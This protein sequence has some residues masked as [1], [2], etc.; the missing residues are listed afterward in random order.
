M[1]ETVSTKRSAHH[2]LSAVSTACT[3]SPTPVGTQKRLYKQHVQL[4]AVDSSQQ[5]QTA[6]NLP[7]DTLLQHLCICNGSNR[8]CCRKEGV[9]HP[10]TST[11]NHARRC[12]CLCLSLQHAAVPMPTCLVPG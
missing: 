8:G 10:I 11:F 5:H 12:P 1:Q 4:Q 2:T 9:H 3:A 6:V 7:A